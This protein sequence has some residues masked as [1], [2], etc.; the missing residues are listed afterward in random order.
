M[1]SS[2]LACSGE[3]NLNNHFYPTDYPLE[4]RPFAI[5]VVGYN[6]GASVE[7]TLRSI[8]SQ[9]YDNYRLIYVDDASTDGSFSLAR[10]LIYNSGQ[11]GRTTF[12]RNEER[13]G[14]LASWSQAIRRCPDQEI[15]VLVGGDDWLA[16]EWVLNRLNE[17]YAD[18]DLWLT[19]G[20]SREFPHYRLG[21]SKPFKLNEWKEKGFR[22]HSFV[23]SHLKTFYAGLFKQVDDSDLSYQGQ[24]LMAAADVA[25]MIPLLELA[26]D[27]FQFIPEILYI[28]NRTAEPREDREFA[29]RCERYVRALTSYSPT[30]TLVTENTHE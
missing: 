22:G 18:P 23:S 25:L 15:V 30:S 7:K 29:L 28:S 10:D 26:E 19:Y 24:F 1:H 13:L 11:I 20:Q 8:F 3:E 21:A 6:N 16:H 14:E 9:H 27:H 2:P 5:L 4:N 12:V 17:Y